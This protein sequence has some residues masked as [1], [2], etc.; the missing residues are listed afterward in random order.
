[1]PVPLKPPSDLNAPIPMSAMLP[2]V[3]DRVREARALILSGETVIGFPTG[4][5]TL[6][7]E[8]HGLQRGLHILAAEPGAGK[9]TFALQVARH[10]ARR[11]LPTVFVSFDEGA[12]QLTLK[13]LCAQ[14]GLSASKAA[15]G[16]QDLEPLEVSAQEHH[17]ILSRIALYSGSGSLAPEH[18]VEALGERLQAFSARIGLLVIDY[19]QPWAAARS[20]SSEYRVAIGELV[21]GLRKAALEH[22][23]PVLA[24]SAQNR[25]AQGEA[26]MSSLRESSDLEYSADSV[27]FLTHDKDRLVSPPRRA[28]M[29][30]VSKNRFGPVGLTVPLILDGS[31]GTIGEAM[32]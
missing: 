9:T 30:T 17:E 20:T 22:R 3:L 13:V 27:L 29:L 24:I 11:G 15:G 5:P 21:M 2:G 7:R 6:D 16:R 1:M 26:K 32:R 12:E 18:V 31:T 4:L 28:V 10:G 19:V 25:A 14:S 8:M 23:C